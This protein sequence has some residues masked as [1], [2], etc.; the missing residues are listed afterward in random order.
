MPAR[1]ICLTFTVPARAKR[2]L[3][4]IAMAEVLKRPSL[5]L[6]EARGVVLA[7]AAR[8]GALAAKPVPRRRP[9]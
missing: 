7:R 1:P 6:E 3:D 8:T 9:A 2:T 5:S 4:R